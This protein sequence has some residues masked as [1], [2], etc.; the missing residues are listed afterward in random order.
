[1]RRLKAATALLAHRRE[2]D[3]PIGKNSAADDDTRPATKRNDRPAN[4]P[5]GR[6]AVDFIQAVAIR[7]AADVTDDQIVMIALNVKHPVH[8]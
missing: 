3:I 2:V 8:A 6:D 5:S 1:M 4:R 7:R